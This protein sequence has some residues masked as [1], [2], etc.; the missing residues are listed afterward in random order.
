MFARLSVIIHIFRSLLRYWGL[1]LLNIAGLSIGFAAAMT[2]GLYVRDELSFDRFM[3]GI[4][5]VYLLSAEYGA[6]ERPLVASDKTP[7]GM[8]AWLKADAPEVEAVARLHR[9][10]SPIRSDRI[11]TLEHFYWADPNIFDL[12][13]LRAVSGDLRSALAEPDT[14]VLTQAAA[15]H[16]FGR[17]DVVGRTLLLNGWLTVH[18]T[19]V[20]ADY[21]DNTNL[22]RQIFVSARTGISM[23]TILDQNPT[24]QWAS[25]YTYVRLKPQAR[26]KPDAIQRIAVRH[27]L[28]PHNLPARFQLIA[29]TDLHFAP[30]GDGEMKP[31]GHRDSVLSMGLVAGLILVLAAVNFAGL[32]TAQIDERRDEMA[33]RKA[34]GAR[35]HDLLFQVL[36]EAAA[37]SLISVVAA[38]ALTE[39]LLPVVDR[40][41]GMSLNLWSSGVYILGA[42]AVTLSTGLLGAALPAL[43]LS[44]VSPGRDPRGDNLVS[45]PYLS[46]VGWIAVQFCLLITLL[47]ASQTVYRQW[48][49]ATSKALNFDGGQVL[50]IPVYQGTVRPQFKQDIRALPGV[51]GAALSR[52]TPIL[53]GT[54]PAWTTSPGGSLI[55]FSRHS[56]DPDFFAL[57][58]VPVLAGRTFTDVRDT[59]EVPG[60][61][62][63]NRSAAKAFGYLNPADAVGKRLAYYTDSVARTSTIIG[64]VEDMRLSSVREPFQ[65]MIF[66]NQSTFFSHLSIRLASRHDATTLAAIDRLWR[67]ENPNNG[68]LERYFFSDYLAAQYHDLVQQWW[69]FGLLSVVGLCLS[70]LALTGLS[71]YLARA[72]SREIAIRNALG[73]RA[74]DIFKLRFMPF[75]HPLIFANL[76]AG[77]ISWGLM[78]WWL[79]AFAAHVGIS[80]LSFVIAGGLTVLIAIGTVTAHAMVAAPARSSHPLRSD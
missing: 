13:R 33:V 65:P 28:P 59:E 51:E 61:I 57:Y 76:A 43:A 68:P 79:S 41:L 19:A 26:L 16:Y 25:S 73:A 49:Y 48:S 58:R 18:I 39:R 11:E 64:V 2:I 75:I 60:E 55:Q 54:W 27:W 37:I 4:E 71:I 69:A 14:M 31:R 45:R 34:L 72:R 38:L 62:V 56:I 15:R 47:I 3:P 21:P 20:L 53:D 8:A 29:L 6:A 36:A 22:D 7:A 5:R 46:R 10:E 44:R 40:H 77:L 30:D 80:P 35:Q 1:S 66:D 42:V 24:W 52:F 12:L 63:I 32:M 23:L 78:S 9:M 17:E 50:L 70:V 67:R 74:W